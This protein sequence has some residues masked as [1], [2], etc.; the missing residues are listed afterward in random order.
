MMKNKLRLSFG[1]FSILLFIVSCSSVQQLPQAELDLQDNSQLLDQ[2][3]DIS[4]TINNNINEEAAIDHIASAYAMGGEYDKVVEAADFIENRGFRVLSYSRAGDILWK[5]G[6]Q[7]EALELFSKAQELAGDVKDSNTKTIG[8]TALARSYLASGENDKAYAILD[9]AFESAQD[10]RDLH[11]KSYRQ[12]EIAT[13]FMNAGQ[14]QKAG[15][16][17]QE[18]FDI[19]NELDN[20][21]KINALDKIASIYGNDKQYDMVAQVYMET[22]EP[23]TKMALVDRVAMHYGG[24]GKFDNAV[25]EINK[26]EHPY[27]R[28]FGLAALAQAA[29]DANQYDAADQTIQ[30]AYQTATSIEDVYAQAA[31][32]ERISSAY[33]VMNK[34]EQ[35][36]EVINSIVIDDEEGLEYNNYVKMAALERVIKQYLL[37]GNIDAVRDIADIIE[38]GYHNY[39]VD[40]LTRIALA[41]AEDGQQAE[42]EQLLNTALEHINLIENPYVKDVS[43]AELVEAFAEIDN[44]E[45]AIELTESIEDQHYN[46]KALYHIAFHYIQDGEIEKAMGIA[47]GI[48]D[49]YYQA[50]NLVWLAR[51]NMDI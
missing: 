35:A 9:S 11:L 36:L 16:I 51:K 10:I 30:S 34:P 15:E 23:F 5:Q 33:M 1:L 18:A 40:A 48:E 27:T 13:L 39:K 29:W 28:S 47:E 2:A 50:M 20:I 12:T 32:F 7:T 14:K 38:P 26:I 37:D 24:T 22:E 3:L 21:P 42:A 31:A 41:L 43:L 6:R 49:K 44:F 19:A 4:K 46:D 25:E 45:K 8:L 17:L